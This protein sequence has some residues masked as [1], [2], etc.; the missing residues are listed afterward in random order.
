MVLRSLWRLALTAY[1]AYSRDY[2]SL[3]TVPDSR[4]SEHNVTRLTAR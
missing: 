1:S 2:L 4:P 3:V